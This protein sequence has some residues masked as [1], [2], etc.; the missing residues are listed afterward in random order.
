[1]DHAEVPFVSVIIPTLNRRDLLRKAVE[2]L[3]FQSYPK[4]RYEIIVVD[5]SSTDGTFKPFL[6]VFGKAT[7]I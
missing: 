2:A 4:E 6:K 3:F 5:N 1:M 7:G